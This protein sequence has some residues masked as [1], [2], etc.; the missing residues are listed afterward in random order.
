MKLQSSQGTLIK[1]TNLSFFIEF[2]G[3]GTKL[4][5]VYKGFEATFIFNSFNKLIIFS[6]IP[7]IYGRTVKATDLVSGSSDQNE[8]EFSS[9]N[10]LEGNHCALKF[11]ECSCGMIFVCFCLKHV[12]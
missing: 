1:Q 6:L 4:A 9:A 12:C 8:R 5:I 7:Q 10:L 3:E 2:L 11:V